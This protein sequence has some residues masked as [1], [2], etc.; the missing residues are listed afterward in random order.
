MRIIILSEIYNRY[1]ANDANANV[2]LLYDEYSDDLVYIK[3]QMNKNMIDKYLYMESR[4]LGVRILR[5]DYGEGYI[6]MEAGLL[7]LSFVRKNM[8][9]LP[10]VLNILKQLNRMQALL[11]KE[12]IAHC[13]IKP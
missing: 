5:F 4:G 7:L 10:L 8:N 1:F 6:I 11:K 9:Y 2:K 13:D 12:R 3:R